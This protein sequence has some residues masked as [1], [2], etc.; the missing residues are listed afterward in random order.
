MF[1]LEKTRNELVSASRNAKKERDGKS[2]YEKRLKSRVGSSVREYNNLN[3]N[4]F[5]K[6]NILDIN[7]Q[8]HGETD[9]YIVSLSFG[10]ILNYIDKYI[11]DNQLDL[12]AVARAI[13]DAFNHDDIYIRCSCPDWQYRFN[14]WATKKDI[15]AGPAEIRPAI[16]T[17]PDDS[18][19]DAC[20]HVLLVL[21]NTSWIIKVA[22]VIINYIKYMEEHQKRLYADIIYP[23]V[24]KKK[25]EEPVQ[26]DLFDKDDLEDDSET[27]DKA[28]TAAVERGRFKPGNTQGV[29]FAPSN[30][31][32]Q[33]FDDLDEE[34]VDEV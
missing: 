17:N 15:N 12:S 21:S 2:R 16:E 29:R 31:N 24:Y 28:N 27:I 7:L 10:N 26:L 3:M 22:R 11:K 20:K 4:K 13:I 25:Y 18:L 33:T 30:K 6:D 5:F 8:V 14:Y 32:Q 34:P 19:G 9:N 1:L 23:A